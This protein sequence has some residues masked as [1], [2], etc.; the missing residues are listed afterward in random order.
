MSAT[1]IKNKTSDELALSVHLVLHV[2]HLDHVQVD[3]LL[4]SLDALDGIDNYFTEWVG[5]RWVNLGVQ[6]SLGD[7]DH[8]FSI[9]LLLKF[10]LLQESECLAFCKLHTLNKDSRVN[11]VSDVSLSLSHDL[12]DE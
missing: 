5:D 7:L 10:E 2:H 6:G 4:G 11:T 12:S 9:D 8:E 1:M 3:L